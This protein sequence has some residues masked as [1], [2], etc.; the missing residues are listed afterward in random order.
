MARVLRVIIID[1]VSTYRRLLNIVIGEFVGVECIGEYPDGMSGMKAIEEL[2]PDLIF[3]DVEMPIMDGIEV[4]KEV[5]QKYPNI[6]VIMVSGFDK[7][8]ADITVRAL[9]LGAIDFVPK[10]SE[11]TIEENIEILKKK[12]APLIHV[13]STKKNL[14]RIRQ[15]TDRVSEEVKK[16]EEPIKEKKISEKIAEGKAIIQEQAI[17]QE[18]PAVD[19]PRKHDILL[20]PFKI[21][22]VAIGTSTGG[23]YA[24][25]DVIPKLPA[26]FPVPI[27]L[28]QHMPPSFTA[29]L[30]NSLSKKSKLPV[31][32]AK[33][34]D[35]VEAGKVLLAPGGYH[36]V[37]ARNEADKDKYIVKLEET[38]QVHGCRPSV[39]VLFKSIAHNYQGNVLSVIMTGMGADGT[40]GVRALKTKKCYC[41]IQNEESSVVFGMPKM[42][43]QAN[44]HDEI[45]PL[46]EIAK[47]ITEIV[48]VR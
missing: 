33:N 34:G 47:R 41:L 27:V 2:Q 20:P 12:I 13:F 6:G 37:L 8:Q 44:L 31:Y 19:R 5:N 25:A 39:D 23:P 18:K 22:L 7:K 3:L 32:E 21:D 38:P 29:S 26:N 30:A 36:M 40:D 48:G 10:P 35:L 46:D 9:E 42:V 28:V 4:L 17:P 1:D 43:M 14:E 24:L 15:I 11:P 16:K 45:I